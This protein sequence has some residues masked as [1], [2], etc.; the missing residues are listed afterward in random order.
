VAVTVRLTR[1]GRHKKPFYRIVATDSRSPREGRFLEVLGTYDPSKKEENCTLNSDKVKYW[2]GQ[3][4][5]IS[6]T[7]KSLLQKKGLFKTT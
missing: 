2:L 7:V 3:G 6:D 1:A 4:A 5:T